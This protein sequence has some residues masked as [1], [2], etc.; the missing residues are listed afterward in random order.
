MKTVLCE[1]QGNSPDAL[2]NCAYAARNNGNGVGA[3]KAEMRKGNIVSS[4]F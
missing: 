1:A 2:A 3:K 4:D